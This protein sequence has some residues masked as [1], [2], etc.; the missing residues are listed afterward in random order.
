MYLE[1]LS[2][3]RNLE[4]GIAAID[5]GADAVYIGGP[6]FGARKDAG[7]SVEDIAA[8][9]SYAHQFG[10]RVF[11]TFN[12]SVSEDELPEMHRMMLACQE[13]G[14]DAFIVRDERIFG[15]KDITVPLHASTQCAI[16]TVEDALRYEA[17]GAGRLVLERELSLD[18]IRAIRAAV[19]CELEF[20]V[21]GAL[22]VCYSGDCR[23]SEYLDGRSADRGECIQACRSMYD[24]VDAS[25]RT[26]VRDKALLSLKDF[27]LIAR[28]G[29]LVDAGVCSFKIEGRL[30]SAAYVRNVTRAYS[31]ALNTLCGSFGPETLS[32]QSAA[33]TAPEGAW[34]PSGRAASGRRIAPPSRR[35]AEAPM[36][37]AAASFQRASFG[38]VTG[39]FTPDLSKT[40]NRGYTELYLDGRRG[41]EWSSMD[42]PANLG[43]FVGTVRRLRR[44]RAALE[45]TLERPG[46]SPAR[47]P[48]KSSSNPGP[49]SAVE[50]H[51]GDGF[52]FIK[53]SSIVGFRGDV[54]EGSTI[55]CQSADG[56]REG[57]RLY[58]NI[59][60][61]FTRELEKNLPKRE[62]PVSLEVS[63]SGGGAGKWEIVLRASSEDGRLVESSFKADV[64]TAENRAR[65][66][67]MF[68][69]QLSKRSGH[70][71]FSLD[72]L[73]ARELPL[74]AAGT[75]NSMRRL[76]AE[77]LDA[78]PCGRVPMYAGE[79]TE[80]PCQIE[81]KTSDP[82]EKIAGG[83]SKSAKNARASA[84]LMRTR[85]CIRY[86]LGLCPVHQGA[87]DT[88]PLF[89]VN[90]G[91]RLA[92]GF[93]CARCEMT[94][95][96]VTN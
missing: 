70:Y 38:R 33:Q 15:W 61:A 31:L 12:I 73:E 37:L 59:D 56:L 14:A 18:D 81:P 44:D 71:V 96:A 94:V 51:N 26:L 16:R 36:A 57:M 90:N 91:R 10:A 29:D 64:D 87:K 55:R 77:D 43:V 63:V 40:F 21:H 30:K 34:P 54:C 45:I 27:N 86:E 75:L 4:I 7:N 1:L 39:G 79:A 35:G 83:L 74:L 69:E 23:L 89:L 20:F 50:L 67:A 60:A 41:P 80:E 9:C 72:R 85:Y 46:S 2:P 28:L 47:K 5:S 19:K 58:R 24:L 17:L 3:A 25:G 84:Q 76:I 88:G 49:N 93:D 11:V 8:L 78:Q 53:G 22:C 13:A 42:A 32:P 65:A 6:F 62:I 48:H 66:A 52:A 92:L 95:S 68:R 82:S